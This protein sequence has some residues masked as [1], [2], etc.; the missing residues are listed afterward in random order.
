MNEKQEVTLT[1]GKT[2]LPNDI[3][4]YS[5]PVYGERVFTREGEKYQE[6]TNPRTTPIRQRSVLIT[7]SSSQP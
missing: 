6:R 3:I 7:K 2:A 1:V 4:V 5:D